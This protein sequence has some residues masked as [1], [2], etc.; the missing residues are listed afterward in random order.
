MEEMS[1]L[2]GK[3]RAKPLAE[4]QD[5]DNVLFGVVNV[6]V[7]NHTISQRQ[8]GNPLQLFLHLGVLLEDR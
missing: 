7:V 3:L 2:S 5:L 8:L 6:A 1:R 4:L